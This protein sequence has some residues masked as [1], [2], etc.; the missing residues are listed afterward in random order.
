MVITKFHTSTGHR[1]SLYALA[2]G[3][4]AQQVLSA[5][6]EGWVVEWNRSAPDTGRVLANAETQL[7]ALLAL[8]EPHRLVAGNMNGGLHWID[9]QQPEQ[10]RNLQHHQK[11]VFDLQIHAEWL[12]S[13]GGEGTLT[14]WAHQEARSVESF[15]L[16]NR[17]LRSLALAP[18]RRE[19]A[20]GS[21]DGSIYLLDLDTLALKQTLPKAHLP[22]V[23]TL[24][25]SPDRRYLLSGGRDAMLR[26]WDLDQGLALVSEQAAHW[27]TI[28]HIVFSPDGRYFATASRDK[29]IK[30]WDAGS[31][32][33]LNVL[34]TIRDG[35]HI[36]SVN[37]L[38]WLSAD[39]LVSGSDDRS[40]IWWQIL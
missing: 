2:R 32:A 9:L 5:G 25:Y 15:Q 38:L 20:V 37:R 12:F 19:L 10:T 36:N 3:A 11:G 30:I 22:S 23:F 21:S 13:A 29:T 24:C 28:N 17:P 39:C 7:F 6:G 27:Y 4:A 14:R 35:G 8:P 33:L 1:S 16:S 26:V 40:L 31:F 18:E 34:D